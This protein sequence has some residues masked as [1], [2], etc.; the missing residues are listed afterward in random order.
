MDEKQYYINDL[1]YDRIVNCP[2]CKGNGELINKYFTN[3]RHTALE[4][5]GNPLN[6]YADNWSMAGKNETYDG[7][8]WFHT[9]KKETCL[10]CKGLGIAYAYFESAEEDCKDCD[11]KGF[12]TIDT[13]KKV[14]IGVKHNTAQ[15]SCEQC[16]ESGRVNYEYCSLRTIIFY[17]SD[18]PA[19]GTDY[20]DP[21][22]DDRKETKTFLERTKMEF[23]KIKI[24]PKNKKVLSSHKNRFNQERL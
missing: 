22:R 24:T 7:V 6:D 3:L 2:K 12:I 13:K 23:S 21:D 14:E 10:F 15:K 9:Y 5:I 1:K 8:G 16:K 17:D 19:I 4:D 11:G 20:G 18:L